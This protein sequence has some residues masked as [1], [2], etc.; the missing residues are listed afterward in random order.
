MRRDLTAALILSL[1]IV[2]VSHAFANETGMASAHS[3]RSK[4]NKTCFEDHAHTG[5]ADGRTKN[6]AK[7]AAIREWREFTAWEYGS[8]WAI[9]R[10]ASGMTVS[11]T[12]AEVGWSARVEARACRIKKRRRSRSRRR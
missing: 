11:Y 1:S 9:Y 6:A 4:G 7:K 5:G 3:W 10:R 8:N 12:K 2:T